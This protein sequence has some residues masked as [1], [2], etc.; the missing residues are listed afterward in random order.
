MLLYTIVFWPASLVLSAD[1]LKTG[2]GSSSAEFYILGGVALL[3]AFL[4]KPYFTNELPIKLANVKNLN[5][6]ILI[7]QTNLIIQLAILEAAVLLNIVLY[8]ISAD[9]FHAGISILE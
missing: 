2:L 3:A 7:F 4:V 1:E 8:F 9:V 5:E 6:K